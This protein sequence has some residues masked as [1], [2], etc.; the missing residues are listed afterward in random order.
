MKR[1]A[2]CPG[3]YDPITRGHEDIVRRAAK[4]FGSCEVVVMDNR[5]KTYRFSAEERLEGEENVSVSYYGGMLYEYLS[6]REDAVLVKGI[7]NEKDFLY[8]KE[9]AA[10]N[11]A[12]CGVETLY[13]DAKEEY[14]HLS[15]TVVREKLEK[16]EDLSASLSENV[17]KLLQNKL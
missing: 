9:M 7:R 10:F 3:S 4:V 12:H 5:E 16:K 6:G 14:S 1:I 13:L 15:S 8:E 17:V 11:Y 2:V